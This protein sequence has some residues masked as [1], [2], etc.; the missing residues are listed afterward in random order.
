MEYIVYAV[1]R[2]ASGP[3]MQVYRAK[4][5]ILTESQL[6]Y[7]PNYLTFGH[8]GFAS[9]TTHTIGA[10]LN[11]TPLLLTIGTPTLIVRRSR[12]L[13]SPLSY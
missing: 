10:L 5:A 4:Y 9:N 3:I 6:S 7:V 1:T 12:R 13:I 8:A 2:A 11:P